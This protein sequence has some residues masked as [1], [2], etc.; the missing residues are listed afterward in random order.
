MYTSAI[1]QALKDLDYNRRLQQVLRGVDTYW[2]SKPL[3]NVFN[4]KHSLNVSGGEETIRYSL[5]LNYDSNKGVMKGSHRTRAGAGLTIDY[6]PKSWLQ[7]MNSITYNWT[8]TEDS[9]YGS[10]S[11]Y[12]EMK[13]YL[14]I[15]D[16]NGELLQNLQ[17]GEFKAAN[18]LYPVKYLESYRGKGKTDDITDNFNVNMYFANGLQFKGQFSI[19]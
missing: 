6:R 7:L 15:Y 2:L 11:T 16:D 8:G 12:A 18:P 9:P 4:H 5:D 1:D 10:F 17:A 3:R 13:P 14:P 19:N